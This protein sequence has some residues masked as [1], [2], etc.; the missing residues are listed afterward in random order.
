VIENQKDVT[1]LTQADT[2]SLRELKNLTIAASGLRY[3]APDAFHANPKLTHLNLSSNY[4]QSL[5]WRTFYPLALQELVLVGNP[6]LCSCG[7]RWLLL[8]KGSGRGSLG[9]QSLSCWQDSEEIPLE[10][11]PTE[12]CDPPEVWID[13]Q[14]VP[15]QQGENVNLTCHFMGE[16]L[17]QGHW[18]VPDVGPE[19]LIITKTSD[20]EITL[21][22][23]NV[24]SSFNRKDITCR[25]E[26]EAGPSEEAVQLNVT[27][28]AVIVHLQEAIPQHYWC[29]PFS[30][31]GNPPPALR[32]LFNGSALVEGPYIHTKIVEYEHNSTVAHGCLQLNRPTHVNNGNYTLLARN[33][34]GNDTRTVLGRFMDNP[35]SFNPEEPIVAAVSLPPVGKGNSTLDGPVETSEEHTFG[36]SVAVALAVVACLFLSVMLIVLNKCGRHSKFGI[37]RAAVLA[38]DDDLAMSLHFMN[39]GSS[40]QS[41]AESKLEGLKTNFIENPQYFCDTC[42]HHIK[43]RDIVLKWE[44]GEGAFGKVFLAECYNLIPEQEKMLVAVKALKEA[45]ESARLDFQREAELL[46]VLQHE[47]IVKFYGVCTEGEP[48]VMVF[49][50]MKHGDLNRFLRS[51]GPDAKILDNGNGHTFGQLTL[52]QMLQIATQI[53]SGM[54]YL[55]SLHFVHRDLATRNCLVGHHLVVKIGDFGM[56]RDIYSTDYYRVGGRTMLPIRWMPPE[57]ILYRKFTAESDIWSFG[58]VLWEIFT[59]GKQPWYQLSNTEAIECIT[60]GREL[61]RPRTCPSEVYTIMQGCWQREP[62]QRQNIKEIHSRL[63]ALV[64]TPPIY[65]DVLG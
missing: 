55:A 49:E 17:A 38:Q 57:S 64:K 10:Q 61:E 21:Q 60:Q 19:P 9:N 20:S 56:S 14:D 42:V 28:P 27:F 33:P 51:H 53:A 26:N 2:K 63:Q 1:N 50:Y 4:L 32:W 40:P 36:V 58:V 65:L 52:S 41:S 6:F 23:F 15:V 39:L 24:S 34:L 62:Q 54:V 16:P 35:F 46:T 22:I 30:V 47:H 13:Y 3:I 31:D 25:A 18:I 11:L 5:S 43:R 29:I 48:L 8:W 44:L 45:T 7:I 12:G 37:N 59:Y